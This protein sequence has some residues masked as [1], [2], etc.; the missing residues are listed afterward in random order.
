MSVRLF[1]RRS[2]LGHSRGSICG[3]PGPRQRRSNTAASLVTASVCP[4]SGLTPMEITCCSAAPPS[5]F[6]QHTV[7]IRLPAVTAVAPRITTHPPD[8]PCLS[9]YYC[10]YLVRAGSSG[11]RPS[12]HPSITAPQTKQATRPSSHVTLAP[13]ALEAESLPARAP[14]IITSPAPRRSRVPFLFLHSH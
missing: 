2:H 13:S 6:A 1:P 10:G 3:A 8:P 11:C 12:T 5:P 7:S 14:I 9:Y 4:L